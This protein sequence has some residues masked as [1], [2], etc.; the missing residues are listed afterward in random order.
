MNVIIWFYFPTWRELCL[1]W[2]SCSLRE[3]WNNRKTSTPDIGHILY[4]LQLGWLLIGPQCVM[5]HNPKSSLVSPVEQKKLKVCLVYQVLKCLMQ[6]KRDS[7]LTRAGIQQT[8]LPSPFDVNWMLSSFLLLS[9]EQLVKS[10]CVECF[11]QINSL[12]RSVSA[13]ARLRK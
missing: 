5:W 13:A 3:V 2:R 6:Y 4:C 7:Q 12:S 11:A 8:S 1:H 9:V 10:V